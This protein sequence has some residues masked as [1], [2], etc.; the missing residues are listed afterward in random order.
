MTTD[1]TQYVG[2]FLILLINIIGW[3]RAAESAKKSTLETARVAKEITIQ[4][5]KRIEHTLS[6]LPCEVDREYVLKQGKL[7]QKVNDMDETLKRIE[8][9]LDARNK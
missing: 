7:I 5:I 8:K 3:W 6:D 1:Q 9:K 4:E 2:W